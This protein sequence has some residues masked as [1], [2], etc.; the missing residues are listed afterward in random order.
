MRL[1][2]SLPLNIRTAEK[3]KHFDDLAVFDTMTSKYLSVIPRTSPPG[4]ESVGLLVGIEISLKG[5][6]SAF[7]RSLFLMAYI[8]FVGLS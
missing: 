5:H 8:L 4:T 2:F 1:F 7:C 3:K 6:S